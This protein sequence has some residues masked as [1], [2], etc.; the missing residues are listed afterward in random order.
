ME[1]GTKLNCCHCE[2]C[3]R[4]ILAIIAEKQDPRLYGFEVTKEVLNTIEIEI[5]KKELITKSTKQMWKEIRKKF[6]EDKNFW[7]EK[8]EINW[9]LKYHI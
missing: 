7:K 1:R 3:Y 8:E 9:I 5:Q 2:K 4:T 6:L